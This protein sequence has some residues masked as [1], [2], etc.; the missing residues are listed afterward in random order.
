MVSESLPHK[1]YED[2]LIYSLEQGHDGPLSIFSFGEDE[3]SRTV[4]DLEPVI[5]NQVAE[6]KAMYS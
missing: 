3:R 5:D 4:E 2:T 1:L 6:R